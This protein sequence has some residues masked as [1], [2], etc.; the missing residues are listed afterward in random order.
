MKIV[1]P[2][3][4]AMVLFV[5]PPIGAK[6]NTDARIEQ[7][8]EDLTAARNEIGALET[9]IE[10]ADSTYSR[11]EG[12]YAKALSR[13]SEARSGAGKVR[14][15]IRKLDIKLARMRQVGP[16]AEAWDKYKNNP[17]LEQF[18]DLWTLVEGTPPDNATK[19]QYD[20]HAQILHQKILRKGV[21][22]IALALAEIGKLTISLVD[23]LT[24]EAF[25]EPASQMA[26]IFKEYVVDKALEATGASDIFGASTVVKTAAG[27]SD[28]SG[29]LG[30]LE[31]KAQ[32]MADEAYEDAKNTLHGLQ[33]GQDLT[34][35]IEK[36]EKARAMAETLLEKKEKQ[37]KP[38]QSA[39][40]TLKSQLDRAKKTID[41]WKEEKQTLVSKASGLE[42]KIAD[43]RILAAQQKA[44]ESFN[45]GRDASQLGSA[46]ATAVKLYIDRKTLAADALTAGLTGYPQATRYH[47]TAYKSVL[48]SEDFAY[49]VKLSKGKTASRKGTR[50]V[51]PSM[52]AVAY[53]TGVGITA[54]SA[55]SVD[56]G[57][58]R[59]EAK[60]AGTGTVTAS[61]SGGAGKWVDRKAGETTYQECRRVSK[62]VASNPIN[63][64]VWEAESV[65]FAGLDPA[66]EKRGAIDFFLGGGRTV[67]LTP[68]VTLTNGRETVVRDGVPQSLIQTNLTGT[69]FP[70]TV[71][72]GWI[73][74]KE[75]STT[76]PA[77]LTLQLGGTGPSGAGF[78]KK[79]D[80]TANRI[81][82]TILEPGIDMRQGRV[83][84]DEPVTCRLAVTGEADMSKYRVEWSNF[85]SHVEYDPVTPF[86]RLDGRW[87]SDNVIRFRSQGLDL[88][89]DLRSALSMLRKI[90]SSSR[91]R[92][93]V[94]H[95][96]SKRAAGRQV[97]IAKLIPVTPKL[98]RIRLASGKGAGRRIDFFRPD[99]RSSRNLK[100]A[101]MGYFS[102]GI[103]LWIPVD[104]LETSWTGD[105]AAAGIDF[106]PDEGL[107]IPS[108]IA[109]F[110]EVGSA[111]L[112]VGLDQYTA[113]RK[114]LYLASD[115]LRDTMTFTSNY[116]QVAQGGTEAD[117]LIQARVYGPAE[118]SNCHVKWYFLGDM[119]KTTG[120][121]KKDGHWVSE[122]PAT[123]GY[124]PRRLIS[125]DLLSSSGGVL[126]SYRCTQMGKP[127]PPAT[128]SVFMP[129]KAKP[130]DKVIVTAVMENVPE[131]NA[132]EYLCR[133]QVDPKFGELMSTETPVYAAGGNQGRSRTT[134][135]LADDFTGQV[136]VPVAAELFLRVG[137]G[138]VE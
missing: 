100:I 6:A 71:R 35:E 112:E 121:S 68:R 12:V 129:E 97:E 119:K 25:K 109:R 73:W 133:W 50:H 27:L 107:E 10:A 98:E 136:P 34:T 23:I 5:A 77:R 52:G 39:V 94:V 60:R 88:G 33:K 91:P 57:K 65:A 76:G 4:L 90:A 22:G 14:R 3:A 83:P 19:D 123:G 11:L 96:D 124:I 70:I 85:D 135:F 118:L 54:F 125:V 108:N 64:E 134:L 32:S 2:L 101:V 44:M 69:H 93:Q 15:Q 122:I 78:T 21:T 104:Y 18:V 47:P 16:L 56:R 110:G 130:G 41:G 38:I 92:A 120:F 116:L 74:V 42:E 53:D 13:L 99:S 61:M 30:E 17:T 128:V 132:D 45:A 43:Y 117:P 102:G 8:G 46:Y 40:D 103:K 31:D 106:D 59:I 36:A 127:L 111:V 62:T 86:K 126:A 89:K 55:V 29:A 84:L 20:L 9:K 24:G 114:E 72:D 82:L 1:V 48:K 58:F 28:A 87:V 75:P 81:A 115:E 26:D 113:N 95:K 66:E 37:L 51:C 105:L 49:T 137:V 7:A 63:V 80:L 131:A 138:D 79:F 67:S